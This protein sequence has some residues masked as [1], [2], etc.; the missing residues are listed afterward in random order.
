MARTLT[1]AAAGTQPPEGGL[2][3]RIRSNLAQYRLYRQTLA[4]LESLTDRELS[5]LGLSRVDIRA[6]AYDSVYR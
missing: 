4:E 6:I 5:D 3:G 1:Y 2:L